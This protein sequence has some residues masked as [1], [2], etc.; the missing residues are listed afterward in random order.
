MTAPLHLTFRAIPPS[1]AL[2]ERIETKVAKLNGLYPRRILGCRVVV[3]APHRH[4]QHGN[5]YRVQVELIVPGG[6]LTCENASADRNSEDA[7]A[8]IDAVFDRAA[9][10]LADQRRSHHD[11]VGT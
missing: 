9:R 1:P 6:L 2:R 5:H 3:D 7:Y 10:L 8:C 11:R 4:H